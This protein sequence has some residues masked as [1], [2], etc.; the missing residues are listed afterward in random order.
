MRIRVRRS[1]SDEPLGLRMAFVRL[2]GLWL[3][4][5]PLLLGFLP[6]LL[7]HRRRGLQDFLAASVVVHVAAK[8]GDRV[9]AP[10]AA[11]TTDPL[12]PPT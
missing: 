5:I 10:T 1:E 12:G 11:M 6:I 2:V 8:S 7:H 4:A 3:A 9:G